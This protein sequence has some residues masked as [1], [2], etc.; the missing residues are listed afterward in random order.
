MLGP[1]SKP[2]NVRPGKGFGTC[3]EKVL[4]MQ[5]PNETLLNT[6]E[7][8]EVPGGKVKRVNPANPLSET[9]VL[10]GCPR[11]PGLML[12]VRDKVTDPNEASDLPKILL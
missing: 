7:L 8:N 6:E 10:A 2:V 5:A 3:P 4:T 9:V 12:V 11:K 1:A